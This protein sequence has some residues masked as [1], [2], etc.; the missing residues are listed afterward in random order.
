MS[1]CEVIHIRDRKPGDVYIGRP[2]KGEDGYFGNPHVVGFCKF[3]GV[4]HERGDAC[5]QERRDDENR[6][7]S[8]RCVGHCTDER[9]QERGNEHRETHG[10]SDLQFISAKVNFNKDWEEKCDEERRKGCIGKIV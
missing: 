1:Q 5:G 4:A 7:S 8:A 9:H 2:G 10:K 6:H 3:C